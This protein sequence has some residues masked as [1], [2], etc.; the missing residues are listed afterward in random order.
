MIWSPL[1]PARARFLTDARGQLHHCA[2]FVSGFG[3][4]YLAPVDDD[5]HTTMRWDAQRG[6][7]VSHPAEGVSVALRLHDL[8]LLLLRDGR[9]DVELPAHGTSIATLEGGLR[10]ALSGAGMDAA[11]YTLR[12]HYE[13]PAHPVA[14]GGAFDASDRVAF[15]ELAAWY[16]NAALV[17]EELRVERGGAPVEC[18]PHHFDLATLM[19]I[20]RGRTT[21]AGLVPGDGYYDEPYFYANAY[22]PPAGSALEGSVGG[23]GRWHT[24]EWVGA[25]LPGAEL[26][27]VPA[28]QQDQVRHFLDSALDSLRRTL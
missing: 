21:G 8:V 2:Q 11:R 7:L 17:L 12:R 20:A 14:G 16:G 4:S 27:A 3:I 19:T 15:A 28:E 6:A 24:F 10:A 26:T 18:W 1:D 9:A 13:I 22:P 25:V 23:G 5:R